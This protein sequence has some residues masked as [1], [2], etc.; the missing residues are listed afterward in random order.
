MA[1]SLLKLDLVE[2]GNL[3]FPNKDDPLGDLPNEVANVADI[4]TGIAFRR[5][6]KKIKDKHPKALPVGMIFYMSK[7]A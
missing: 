6:Y 3:M 5:G 1:M 2:E 7:Y 4:D